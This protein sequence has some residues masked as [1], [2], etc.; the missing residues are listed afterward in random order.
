[1]AAVIGAGL[2]HLA[3]G[4]DVGGAAGGVGISVAKETAERIAREVGGALWSGPAPAPFGETRIM[5]GALGGTGLALDAAIAE[6]I[7]GGSDP[8]ALLDE[9]AALP[10]GAGGVH[11]V[12]VGKE[13]RAVEAREQRSPA[14]RVR[15]AIEHGALAVAALL[16]PAR[17]A[18]LPLDEMWL[19]G[20]ATGATNGLYVTQRS[21]PRGIPQI[22]A[23][24]LGLP[25]VL[26]R[27]PE[28][29][30]AGSAALAGL[31]AGLYAT[32]SE[33]AELIAV[34]EERIDPEVGSSAGAARLLEE[35]SRS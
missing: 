5:G 20:P 34:A 29:A 16:A 12:L 4:V 35:F 8:A 21:V 14:H 10:L 28:A 6:A 33:A 1:M 9:V 7:A 11:G 30:A 22:R 13:V 23:N 15:A 24:L 17:A 25:V 32:L 26:P 19:S 3:R 2:M 18:G 31:G 27:I